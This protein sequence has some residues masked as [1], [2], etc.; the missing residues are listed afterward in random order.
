MQPIGDGVAG[1]KTNG[2]G[3]VCLLTTNICLA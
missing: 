1:V 3:S 2:L